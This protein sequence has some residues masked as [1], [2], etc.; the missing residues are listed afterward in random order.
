MC[1]YDYFVTLDH[2]TYDLASLPAISDPTAWGSFRLGLWGP[3]H[4]TPCAY[5]ESRVPT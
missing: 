4:G 1:S 5:A 2:D 3:E